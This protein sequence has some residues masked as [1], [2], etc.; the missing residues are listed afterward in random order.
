MWSPVI[1]DFYIFCFFFLLICERFAMLEM[2]QAP[3]AYPKTVALLFGAFHR[4]QMDLS[5][6]S[7]ITDISF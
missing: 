5:I 7:L 1:N 2:E 6:G 3:E 4:L